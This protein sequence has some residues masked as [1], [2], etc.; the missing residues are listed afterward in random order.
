MSWG[1]NESGKL[2]DGSSGID[3]AVD[4]PSAV[5]DLAGVTAISAGGDHSL[6]IS[7]LPR[8]S[9]VE[10]MGGPFLGG[11]PVSITG[12]NFT[13]ATAVTF[14]SRA[15]TKVKVDSPT[16]IS[17]VSPP[18]S[19]VVDVTVTGPAGTSETVSADRFSYEPTVTEL[20]PDFGRPGGGSA[21]RIFGRGLT[22]AT[23]VMFGSK[24]ASRLVA[25]HG[26]LTAVAPAGTGIVDVTVTNPGGTSE[27]VPADRFSYQPTVTDVR[28][29]LGRPAGGSVVTITGTNFRRV[30]AVSF[31]TSPAK[32]FIVSSPSSI[33]A[34]SP[35][36]AGTV[37][38]TVT[39]PGGTSAAGTADLFAYAVRGEFA[40]APTPELQTPGYLS[41][42]TCLSRGACV[43]VGHQ[44]TPGGEVLI[45]GWNGTAWSTI[46]APPTPKSEPPNRV[47]DTRLSAVS[48]ASTSY[49]VAV[50][51][52]ARE[53][54]SFDAT[55]P[56]PV[57]DAWNGAAWSQASTAGDQAG[58]SELNGVSCVSSSFC[59]AVGQ[60]YSTVG[61]ELEG[62]LA[63]YWDGETWSRLA[64]P[65]GELND[66][67][68]V[69]LAF[70]MAVGRTSYAGEREIDSWNGTAWSVVP[71]PILTAGEADLY[72]VSCTSVKRC[73][74]VGLDEHGALVET[75][76]GS[77]WSILETPALAG[78]AALLSV[79]CVSRTCAAVGGDE[80][81]GAV[82]TLVE[83]S[84]G[85]TWSTVPSANIAGAIVGLDG[86]SCV[87]AQHQPSCFSVGEAKITATGATQALAESG[88]L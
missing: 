68:C 86:V 80:T 63:E 57:I 76:N 34:V 84:S 87:P 53:T 56:F 4:V 27:I 51:S 58:Q 66:V 25:H 19:G 81:P 16:S 32:R 41:G 48:C 20:Q 65:Y 78:H 74:A 18:G 2:G 3:E 29:D 47:L 50:G 77:A 13:G 62:A 26:S 49:C 14:G 24:P 38:V 82:Q 30:T 5:T 67:S 54:P 52:G 71:N 79:S 70:C 10:P 12:V 55:G 40:I 7:S 33:T 75:W 72:G 85:S 17:A 23:S 8:V 36:G 61:K 59:M 42:I 22:G 21:V 44:S 43:A 73:M 83:A 45:E 64:T 11:T 28:A 35:A 1:N 46:A 15:A 60:K 39:G 69:S 6:A 31:G 9:A 88:E 37:H